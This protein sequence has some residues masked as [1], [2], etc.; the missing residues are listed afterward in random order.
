[1]CF[2]I[3][4]SLGEDWSHLQKIKQ[5]SAE[6]CA[7]AYTL[8]ALNITRT[9]YYTSERTCTLYGRGPGAEDS[10]SYNA[11]FFVKLLQKSCHSTI[12]AKS[13]LVAVTILFTVIANTQLELSAMKK[14]T[15]C[16]KRCTTVLH[17]PDSK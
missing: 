2:K 10:L 8:P 3:A 14:K 16:K 6:T 4:T 1:M 11:F 13:S 17:L 9:D 5:V 15:Q 7:I 12:R